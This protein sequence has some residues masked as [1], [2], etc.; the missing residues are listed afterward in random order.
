MIINQMMIKNNQW[1]TI[2]IGACFSHKNIFNLKNVILLRK[3]KKQFDLKKTITFQVSDK[4]I[5]LKD[6]NS[7]LRVTIAFLQYK[8]MFNSV[9]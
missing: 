4:V 7:C 8:K 5:M 9:F 1:I 3:R 2:E 6:Y